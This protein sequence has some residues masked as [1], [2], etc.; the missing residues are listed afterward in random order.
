MGLIW[1]AQNRLVHYHSLTYF[2][3]SAYCCHK[4]ALAVSNQVCPVSLSTLHNYGVLLNVKL[5]IMKVCTW[6]GPRLKRVFVSVTALC[7]Y[8][9][10]ESALRLRFSSLTY[11]SIYL[12]L[13][14]LPSALVGFLIESRLLWLRQV[15]I[16]A[17][18]CSTHAALLSLFSIQ[19]ESSSRVQVSE[20]S[21]RQHV[22]N[23]KPLGSDRK[24]LACSSG[25]WTCAL[26]DVAPAHLTTHSL[27]LMSGSF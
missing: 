26:Q 14:Y 6:K 21:S 4:Y 16:V 20:W 1:T 2:I 15:F 9:H 23:F 18:F 13:T 12:F 17:H 11:D 19:S 3:D 22:G 24:F 5:Q 7:L 25:I 10:S 27:A 8:H